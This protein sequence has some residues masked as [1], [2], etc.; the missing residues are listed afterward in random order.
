MN[1]YNENMK[2]GYKKTYG[3]EYKPE[4]TQPVQQRSLT[5]G[6]RVISVE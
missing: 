4:V 3:E 6:A 2:L 1:K 5:G